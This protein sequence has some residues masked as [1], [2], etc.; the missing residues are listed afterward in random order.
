VG[1]NADG[2]K[3]ARGFPFL[4]VQIPKHT[5]QQQQED[6]RI[7]QVFTIISFQVL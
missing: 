5:Q 3:Q 1:S 6:Y 4:N 2:I 7:K